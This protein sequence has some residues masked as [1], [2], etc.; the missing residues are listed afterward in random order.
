MLAEFFLDQIKGDFRK[1]L[2]KLAKNENVEVEDIQVQI[3]ISQSQSAEY[4][5]DY[6]IFRKWQLAH[7]KS[8]FKDILGIKIDFLQKE[9]TLSPVIH[10]LLV[11]KIGEYNIDPSNFS[12]FLFERNKTINIAFH[13]GH[14]Y[15]KLCPLS[16]LFK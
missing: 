7:A 4:G 2:T 12:A 11:R 14:N 8:T 3:K 16:D 10:E 6:A 13:D 15:L 9:A 5:L 1:G